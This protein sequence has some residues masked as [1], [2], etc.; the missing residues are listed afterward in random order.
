MSEFFSKFLADFTDPQN[1]VGHIAYV[2]L[3]VSMMMRSMNWLRFFAI[4]AGTIS[5][6][7]YSILGDYVSMFW[8]ALFSLVNLGQLIILKIEN[9]RGRFSDEENYFISTCLPG[10][11]KLHTRKL[12]KF[13]AWTEVQE[14]VP[15]TTQ[16]TCPSKLKFIVSGE[17]II[18]RDG[19]QLGVAKCGDFI[20]EM[21]FLT[22]KPASA[23]VTTTE[24]TRYLAFDITALREHLQKNPQV[25]HA[26]EASFNRDLV[27]KLTSRSNN[28]DKDKTSADDQS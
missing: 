24:P 17:A 21:S 8:E 18:E 1:L 26:L 11:E 10:V 16:D 22:N 13:G 9:Q 20:G 12:M 25:R 27:G 7:Y 14:G 23:T 3:I 6:I 5:S 4:M 2:L 15:L 28:D 19:K